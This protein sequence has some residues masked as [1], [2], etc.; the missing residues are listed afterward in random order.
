DYIGGNVSDIDELTTRNAQWFKERF[1][2]DIYTEFEVTKINNVDQTL[3]V[4][5]LVNG[6]T[7]V[8]EYDE[9]VLATGSLPKEHPQLNSQEY[10]NVFKVKNINDAKAIY[11]YI[12]DNNVQ[13]I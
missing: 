7:I 11:N 4:T 6:E 2:I 8:Q 12:D 10:N 13:N 5:N 9:L 1:N 3:T